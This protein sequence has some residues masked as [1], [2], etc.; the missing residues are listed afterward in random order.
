MPPLQITDKD[1]SEFSTIGRHGSEIG[2][3]YTPT[4]V[5]QVNHS[6]L[7]QCLAVTEY[8]NHRVQVITRQYTLYM[9][10]CVKSL[11]YPLTVYCGIHKDRTS[12][13]HCSASNCGTVFNHVTADQSYT[14]N[15][16][17]SQ[18]II[19]GWKLILT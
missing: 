9:Y 6:A 7:G 19:L 10:S 3:F 18:L 2:E 16:V 11:S 15:T 14:L 1:F 4:G 12:L 13:Y 8:R 5:V 17:Q